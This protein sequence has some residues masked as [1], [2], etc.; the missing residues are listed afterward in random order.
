MSIK[1]RQKQHTRIAMNNNDALPVA[2][3]EPMPPK[4]ISG[5][6]PAPELDIF[7]AKAMQGMLAGHFAC[8]G[9]DNYW[10]RTEIASEAYDMAEAMMAER[11]LRVNVGIK[12]KADGT[13]ASAQKGGET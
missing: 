8:Y 3:P 2:A 9:H 10:K 13:G 1:H 5:T 7:A 6:S 4:P 11:A 12:P